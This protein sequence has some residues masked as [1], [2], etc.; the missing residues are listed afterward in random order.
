[1]ICKLGVQ[2]EAQSMRSFKL[3][4][5]EF[6]VEGSP[7]GWRYRWEGDE[8]RRRTVYRTRDAAM[9]AGLEDLLA[10]INDE[11]PPKS[12]PMSIAEMQAELA[13]LKARI[14]ALYLIKKA[15]Q[16]QGIR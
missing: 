3:L 6:Y 15:R 11:E 4:G 7:E 2:W 8:G 1:M 12:G 16:V 5:W 9:Q 10:V 13:R 14:A